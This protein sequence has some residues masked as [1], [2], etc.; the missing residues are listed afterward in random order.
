MSNK[1][2]RKNMKIYPETKE[3]LDSIK[4]RGESYDLLID[5]LVKRAIDAGDMPE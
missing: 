1:T 4:R 5:R 2:T 3:L